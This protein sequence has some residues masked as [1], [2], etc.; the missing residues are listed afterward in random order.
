MITSKCHIIFLTLYLVQVTIE[1]AVVTTNDQVKNHLVEWWNKISYQSPM[2]CS[3]NKISF[4]THTLLRHIP[5]GMIKGHI[6][7]NGNKP[8][9][10]LFKG[11][12]K[13]TTY[14]SG[15]GK[16]KFVSKREWKTWQYIERKEFENRNL[17]YDL[18]GNNG[19][20]LKEVIGTFK[21]GSLHGNAKLKWKDKSFS[22]ATFKNGYIHGFQRSWD[23][24]GNLVHAGVYNKGREV[25]F[26]WRMVFG[27][28]AYIDTR[29]INNGTIPW[30]LLFPILNNGSLDNPLAGHF[31]P[32]LNILENVHLS[33]LT[34]IMS[35]DSD[36][37]TTIFYKLAQKQS[38]R[39]MIRTQ[40]KYPFNFHTQSQLCTHESSEYSTNPTRKLRDFFKNVDQLIYGNGNPNVLEGYQVLWHFKPLSDDVNVESSIKFISNITFDNNTNTSMVSILGSRLLGIT[41]SHITINKHGKLNGYCELNVVS[42]DRKYVPRDNTLQWPTHNIKGMF[43]NGELNGI[44]VVN[45]NT[46]S[47]GWLTVKN[48]VIHGPCLFHGL[49]P[50][51]PVSF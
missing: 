11:S 28:L 19:V 46:F 38:Y 3:D 40:T 9:R 47:S 32:H 22:I 41:F 25:G 7:K 37:L 18:I 39:Y 48:G 10:Y 26:H 33:I 43:T 49:Q 2:K 42:K 21:T 20:S 24:N 4:P 15:K 36:C 30:M 45:T 44:A 51:L 17:C 12:N 14:L 16:L 6:C 5:R 35:K 13:T 1:T 50:I 31:L 34:Q 23:S 8:D 27:Q 29:L